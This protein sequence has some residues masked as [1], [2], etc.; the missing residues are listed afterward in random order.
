[1]LQRQ[2]ARNL[3]RRMLRFWKLYLES[4]L[5]YRMIAAAEE[6]A[7]VQ[8]SDSCFSSASEAVSVSSER[9]KAPGIM[10]SSTAP[11]ALQSQASNFSRTQNLLQSFRDAIDVQAVPTRWTESELKRRAR[12]DVRSIAGSMAKNVMLEDTIS[13]SMSQKQKLESQEREFG[14]I[15]DF[16]L[17]DREQAKGSQLSPPL[18]PTVHAPPISAHAKPSSQPHAGSP[19]HWTNKFRLWACFSPPPLPVLLWPHPFCLAHIRYQ[20][21][22]AGDGAVA[23]EFQVGFVTGRTSVLLA[24]T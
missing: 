24:D 9:F 3:V 16:P 19:S 1:M 7:Q 10:A 13:I 22:F 5:N 12:E 8:S 20:P 2:I 15:I 18:P 4:R 11:R 23:G 17:F 14:G 6:G 21:L